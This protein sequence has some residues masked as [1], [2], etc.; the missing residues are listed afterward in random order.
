MDFFDKTRARV[1][2]TMGIMAGMMSGFAV[3]VFLIMKKTTS[4]ERVSDLGCFGFMA[5]WLIMTYH[6]VM[7]SEGY[8]K[9]SAIIE[10]SCIAVCSVSRIIS[11][12][13][14]IDL[15]P[16]YIICLPV[17]VMYIIS[18]VVPTAAAV[19]LSAVGSTIDVD[20]VDETEEPSD[21][22]DFQ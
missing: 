8:L 4:E 2:F 12:A 17:I 13:I 7:E 16:G 18:V 19:Y 5:L 14:C 21:D 6:L 15:I 11:T 22:I 20:E 1:G 9:Q 3:V 10:F